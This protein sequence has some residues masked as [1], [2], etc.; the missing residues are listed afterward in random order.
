M[1]NEDDDRTACNL[2]NQLD[3]EQTKA[4]RE[5]LRC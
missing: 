1:K 3:S 2:L 5:M 4:I